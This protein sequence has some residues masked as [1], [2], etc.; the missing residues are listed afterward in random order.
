M[1]LGLTVADVMT[2][3]VETVTQDVP[4]LD[5]ARRLRGDDIGS[6]VVVDDEDPIGI[7]TDTDLINLMV[8]GGDPATA[9]VREIMTTDLHTISPGATVLTAANRLFDNDIAHL[10]VMDHGELVGILSTADLSHY[11]PQVV[12]RKAVSSVSHDSKHQFSVR[13]E[14]AYEREDWQFESYCVADEGCQVGDRVVFSKTISDEDVR[15][16]AE[17]SGDTNRLHLDDDFAAETR[18]SH[19]IV[20]GTLVSGLIS[21]ALARLPGLTIYLSQDLSFLKP[22]DIGDR[23]TATCEIVED[24]GRGRFMLTTDVTDGDDDL[25]VEGE[26]VVIIDETPD[27]A[28]AS[29]EPL[30]GED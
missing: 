4:A 5:V 27:I 16:F 15:T 30:P 1:A 9:T 17:V 2:R 23:V 28:K 3:E 21:S 6:I 19:R 29:R 26:A 10:I 13:P 7:V 14:T 20:H 18:F 24:L 25:V 11:I 22:V 12:H 8:D